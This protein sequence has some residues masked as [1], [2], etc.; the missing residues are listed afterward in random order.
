[1]YNVPAGGPLSCLDVDEAV[2]G[3]H[4]LLVREFFYPGSN[5]DAQVMY[6]SMKT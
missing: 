6:I 5:I 1:V 4:Y 3:V 2:T